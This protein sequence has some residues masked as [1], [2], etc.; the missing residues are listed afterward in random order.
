VSGE[1]FVICANNFQTRAKKEKRPFFLLSALGGRACSSYHS[2]LIGSHS[3]AV[4]QVY[5][6]QSKEPNQ[7]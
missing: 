4:N 2:P 7:R 6:L 3:A 1:Y 5:A